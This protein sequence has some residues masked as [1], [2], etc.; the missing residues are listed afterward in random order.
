MGGLK[1]EL[2]RLDEAEPLLRLAAAGMEKL[3]TQ[4]KLRASI[5]KNMVNLYTAKDVVE[6]EAG[7]AAEA[8]KW[9]A[10]VENQGT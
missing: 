3:P 2:S 7:H 1:I 10:I 6:P 4:H 5:A 8:A 9:R